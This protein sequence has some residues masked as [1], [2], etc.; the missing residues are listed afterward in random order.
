MCKKN[1][2]AQTKTFFLFPYDK[3][4][5]CAYLFHRIQTIRDAILFEICTNNTITFDS[6]LLISATF[7]QQYNLLLNPLDLI[8]FELHST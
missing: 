2:I 6:H 8:H 5:Q 7:R 1:A 4:F 3:N